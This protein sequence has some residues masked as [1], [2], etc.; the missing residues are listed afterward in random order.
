MNT[1]IIFVSLLMESMKGISSTLSGNLLYANSQHYTDSHTADSIF[2]FRRVPQ[3]Y[4]YNSRA[5]L[6]SRPNQHIVYLRNSLPV[7]KTDGKRASKFKG[8]HASHAPSKK[9]YQRLTSK[10]S[11]KIKKQKKKSSTNKR[12]FVSKHQIEFNKNNTWEAKPNEDYPTKKDRVDIAGKYFLGSINSDFFPFDGSK[13][14]Y[15]KVRKG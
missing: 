13:R 4:G 7:Y 15:L 2:A 10:G 14:N 8:N 12:N 6:E 3:T 9:I 11:E 1:Y 5:Y